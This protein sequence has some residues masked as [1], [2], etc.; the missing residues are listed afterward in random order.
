M[1]RTDNHSHSHGPYPDPDLKIFAIAIL[2]IVVLIIGPTIA[3]VLTT[4]VIGLA[5][6]LASIAVTTLAILIYK[7]KHPKEVMWHNP[8]QAHITLTYEQW[9]NVV[10]RYM[11]PKSSFNEAEIR[12][13]ITRGQHELY[14]RQCTINRRHN[15]TECNG[16]HWTGEGP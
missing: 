7:H 8:T 10:E 12:H 9:R 16:E 3:G 13:L 15:A 6:S 1:K 14:S 5:I 2:A 4:L 11:L